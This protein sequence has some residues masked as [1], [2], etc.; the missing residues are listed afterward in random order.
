MYKGLEPLL[1]PYLQGP[2]QPPVD[3]IRNQ[4]LWDILLKLP[5]DA[6]LLQQ[7]KMLIEQQIVIIKSHPSYKASSI[8]VDVDFV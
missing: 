8:V 6:K 4:F 1:K 5:K 3:R 2:A 7:T